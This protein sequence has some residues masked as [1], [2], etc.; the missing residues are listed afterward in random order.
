MNAILS[1]ILRGYR[2]PSDALVH[3][4]VLARLQRK[5]KLELL[6]SDESS[7]PIHRGNRVWRVNLEIRF[8][9]KIFQGT[10]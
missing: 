9:G 3:T 4:Y 10:E 1:R 6:L 8:V 7:A 2:R 5:P